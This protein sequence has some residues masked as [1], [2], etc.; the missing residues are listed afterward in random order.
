MTRYICLSTYI[1]LNF[2]AQT[3]MAMQSSEVRK[4]LGG[5]VDCQ[6]GSDI[7]NTFALPVGVHWSKLCSVRLFWTWLLI[8]GTPA[9]GRSYGLA[10]TDE[11]GTYYRTDF[12]AGDCRPGTLLP[13]GLCGFRGVTDVIGVLEKLMGRVNQ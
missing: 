9:F 13:L 4:T 1:C 11:A 12:D 7:L 2:Q 5:Y 6:S 10:I 3:S 8:A